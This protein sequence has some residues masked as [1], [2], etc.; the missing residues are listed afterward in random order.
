MYLLLAEQNDDMRNLLT[1]TGTESFSATLIKSEIID[2]LRFKTFTRLNKGAG[3][4]ARVNAIRI[5]AS[6]IA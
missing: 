2:I 5:S 1:I 3:L 4:V 6:F